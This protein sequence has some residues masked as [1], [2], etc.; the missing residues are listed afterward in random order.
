MRGRRGNA[1]ARWRE[2]EGAGSVL[3]VIAM[4]FV[5]LVGTAVVM[6]LAGLAARERVQSAA[7]TAASV[8]AADRV[9]GA[10]DPCVRARLV[11]GAEGFSLV[12]CRP[13]GEGMEVLVH[14]PRPRT[15]LPMLQ[16]RSRAGPVQE[17]FG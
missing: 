9:S 17:A 6:L 11:V 12:A 15:L 8:A 5:V 14:D 2:D 3:V 16:A 7:D 13:E 1:A 4:A 10:L